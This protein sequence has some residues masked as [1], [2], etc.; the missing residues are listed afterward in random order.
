MDKREAF[1]NSLYTIRQDLSVMNQ[2]LLTYAAYTDRFLDTWS[3]YAGRMQTLEDY[4]PFSSNFL[5][6]IGRHN[7]EAEQAFVDGVQA[8]DA[9][10][11]EIQGDVYNQ[12]ATN[13]LAS[14]YS[15][16]IILILSFNISLL[17][18]RRTSMFKY[19]PASY[20]RQ[21]IS[22]FGPILLAYFLPYILVVATGSLQSFTPW[23]PFLYLDIEK[24]IGQ[25]REFIFLKLQPLDFLSGYHILTYLLAWVLAL[26]G[27]NLVWTRWQAQRYNL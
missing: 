24:N 14:L 23:N 10:F 18:G 7:F 4:A 21:V 11:Q 25:F 15:L 12:I 3:R 8:A 19:I 22:Y 17:E 6:H 27:V 16:A 5:Y 9:S 1:L 2:E 26:E 13:L 20:S